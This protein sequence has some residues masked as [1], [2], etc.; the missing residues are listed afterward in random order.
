MRHCYGGL[1]EVL[2]AY[3]GPWTPWGGSSAHQMAAAPPSSS[4]Q[5]PSAPKKPLHWY[6]MRTEVGGLFWLKHHM[7][8]EWRGEFAMGMPEAAC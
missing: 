1:G 7:G 2:P 6:K 3:P 4:S 8:C 5:E